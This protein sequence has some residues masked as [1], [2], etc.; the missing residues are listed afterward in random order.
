VLVVAGAG[1]GKT[2]VLVTRIAHLLE[3]GTLP[4]EVLAFT[5][6]NKA[7]RQ[8]QERVAELVG[9]DRAPYW[10]GT[11][12]ATGARILRIHAERLGLPRDFVIYDSDDQKR[13]LKNVL[14]EMKIDPSQHGLPG[15]RSEISAWKNEDIA[16]A[17][18]IE[19]AV[20]HLQ[21]VRAEIF[22]AYQSA[23]RASRALDFDDLILEAV[24]LLEQHDDVCRQYAQRFRHVLVDE[25]QDTNLLQLLLVRLLSR[26]HGNVFVVGD[27]DQAIYGWRG[28]RVENMLEFEH[29]FR[30]TH[31]L[32]LEQ[33]YRSVGSILDAANAVIAH[34]TNRKG[35][36][37]WTEA[38]AGDP[39][40]IEEHLDAEDEAARV[41]DIIRWERAEGRRLGDIAALYR[42]NA[43]SRLLEEAL[44]RA[45]MPHQVVGSVQFYERREVRD[46]LA[47]LKLVANPSDEV[48][49]Q[50]VINR[51]K[52]R[53]GATSVERLVA[54]ARRHDLAAGQL[55]GRSDLLKAAL[56]SA[57]SR[58]VL[59]FLDQL[60]AWRSD[61][62]AGVS[63]S[64]LLERILAD[65]AYK[66][67]LRV[68]DPATADA[69][70]ENV[71]ELVNMTHAFQEAADGGTLSQFLEQVALVSDQDT[72]EDGE[73]A[74]RLMT[75]HTAKGLEF[76][77]VILTGCEDML[78]PHV[79][80]SDTMTG[81]EEERRLFY[82]AIT[83]AMRRIYLLHAGRRRRYGSYEDSLPSRFLDEIPERC[84]RRREQEKTVQPP[85]ARTLFGARE[86]RPAAP[87]TLT[88]ER[89]IVQSVPYYPG[90][91][92]VHAKFGAGQV[93]R[94]EGQDQELVVTVDF[95]D[96]GR[97][98]MFTKYSH[99]R[100]VD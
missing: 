6:T 1:S 38:G 12:H 23:L 94:V 11:F 97:K 34:N 19:D 69:R 53:I 37:L 20:G 61:A 68:D 10:I 50:R 40:A 58:R 44:R 16:P 2:R 9:P 13:L 48:S 77:I 65:V 100:P 51:P 98:H 49:L 15:L 55:E 71:A 7:A 67:F 41:V 92:V 57:A 56:G 75:I 91:T 66:D 60:A 85:L 93:V 45:R 54:C 22:A 18:A 84:C 14:S 21:K 63:V 89:D 87:D 8:M 17:R 82:V 70:L 4:A 73:G 76:P 5:F 88:W 74:V 36:N 96:H 46:L 3:N 79:T 81:V 64:R 52:R 27:D 59:D 32:R 47:Y 80:V 35:K 30:G 99:L 26:V 29:M 28:A 31:T 24:H 86:D 25:F 95:F 42:T 90:Q 78:L 39:V 43:Q 62:R 33:N 72:I 83:R